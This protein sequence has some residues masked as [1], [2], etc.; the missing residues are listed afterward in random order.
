MFLKVS[1]GCFAGSRLQATQVEGVDIAIAQEKD[2][3][4]SCCDSNG[5]H[6]EKSSDY[7]YILKVEPKGFSGRL[8]VGMRK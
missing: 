6:S 4:G 1:P 7:E 3:G 5:G 8:A 2:D